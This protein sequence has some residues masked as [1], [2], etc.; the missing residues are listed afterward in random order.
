MCIRDRP[1]A[2]QRPGRQVVVDV[3]GH[4]HRD[5][6]DPYLKDDDALRRQLG[7][8]EVGPH[9]GARHLE[10]RGVAPGRPRLAEDPEDPGGCLLYT[11]T[12]SRTLGL[13]WTERCASRRA[14]LK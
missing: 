9:A 14:S 12:P 4:V 10:H 5:P 6:V 8:P 2:A 7:V 3:L 13:A 11:S 1:V